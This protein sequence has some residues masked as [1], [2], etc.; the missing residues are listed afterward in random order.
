MYMLH[1]KC[2]N[3]AQG[4]TPLRGKHA[5]DVPSIVDT[6]LH[7]TINGDIFEVLMLYMCRLSSTSFLHYMF[8][9]QNERYASSQGRKITVLHL[10]IYLLRRAFLDERVFSL[11]GR[12]RREEKTSVSAFLTYW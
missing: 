7:D 6:P 11:R 9:I 10:R 4:F 5:A 1:A 12:F 8:K 2:V 3:V